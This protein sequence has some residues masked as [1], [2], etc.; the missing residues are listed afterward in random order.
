MI[1]VLT[2]LALVLA[3]AAPAQAQATRDM[4]V[5]ILAG[6]SFLHFE[7]GTGTGFTVDLSKA[8]S[9]MTNGTI[10]V[11]GQFT[12]HT[13]S[14][15]DALGIQGGPQVS[16]TPAG[17]KATIFGR[18]GVGITRFSA[19]GFSETDLTFAPGAGVIFAI[20]DTMGVFGQFD[21]VIIKFD[22]G[23]ETGQR[24]A[25]GIVFRR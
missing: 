14:G 22:G 5:N 15:L 18:F 23:S 1:R 19:N 20:S 4:N 25:F 21:I 9:A 10:D 17:S 13:D 7:G 6:V 16:F 2:G 11:F 24:F 8:L 3:L 12:W